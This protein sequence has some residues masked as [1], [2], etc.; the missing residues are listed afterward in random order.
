MIII[1]FHVQENLNGLCD[2]GIMG[3]NQQLPRLGGRLKVDAFKVVTGLVFP[4]SLKHVGVLHQ[5]A[6]R[7]YLSHPF[8]RPGTMPPPAR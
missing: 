1:F 2:R 3:V 5:K 4:Y 6:L 7:R 8:W